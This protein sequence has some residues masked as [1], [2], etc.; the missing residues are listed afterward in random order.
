[1]LATDG[2]EASVKAKME[3][4]I[5]MLQ[6][7]RNPARR[8]TARQVLAALKRRYGIHEPIESAAEREARELESQPVTPTGTNIPSANQPNDEV[9]EPPDEAVAAKAITESKIRVADIDR[10]VSSWDRRM[11]NWRGMLGRR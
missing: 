1:M 2:S 10:A 11:R 9:A 5:T 3:E 4:A 8:K 6:N 7:S